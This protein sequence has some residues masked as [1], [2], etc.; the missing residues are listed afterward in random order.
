MK[1]AEA[2]LLRK[3]LVQKVGQLAPIK[4]F[5]DNGVLALQTKRVKVSDEVDEVS[6]QVPRVTLA[7]ITATFD[8]YATELRK[9]DAAIQQANWQ[10]DV[11]YAEALAPAVK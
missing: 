8:H 2:L 6:I 4:H 9:L 7:D 3:Q 11:N 1:L 10:Y 5:G